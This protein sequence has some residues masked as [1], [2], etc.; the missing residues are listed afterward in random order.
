M[1]AGRFAPVS[2]DDLAGLVTTG[3]WPH[4]RPGVVL[5]FFDGFRDNF[6]V[7]ASLLDRLGLVGWLFVVSG[8]VAT[9]PREQRSFASRHLIDLPYDHG[10]LPADG[11][12]AL[13]PDEVGAL[14]ERGHVVASHTRTHATASPGLVPNPPPAGLEQEAAAS[15]RDLERLAGLPVRALAWRE[16]TPLGASAGADEALTNAG[17]ELL[18]A[19]HAVQGVV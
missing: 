18:F 16:G 15:R 9:P 7:A 2:Y 4:E 11:R 13:S 5:N 12:L 1:L 8:W 14:A 6:E 3:D 10:D 19:N 17:Y